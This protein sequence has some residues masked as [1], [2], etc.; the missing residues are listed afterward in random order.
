VGPRV[1]PGPPQSGRPDLDPDRL[2]C[3]ARSPHEAALPRPGASARRCTTG[4]STGSPPRPA[5]VAHPRR[6]VRGGR[7]GGAR[8]RFRGVRSSPGR[9][10]APSGRLAPPV[11]PV[12]GGRR[13]GRAVVLAGGARLGGHDLPPCGVRESV[14]P[15]RCMAAPSQ[16]QSVQDAAGWQPA[17]GTGP[18]QRRCGRPAGSGRGGRGGPGT[19]V[20]V[21]AAAG[22]ASGRGDRAAPGL[23]LP[24]GDSCRGDLGQEDGVHRGGPFEVAMSGPSS[25]LKLT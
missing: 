12:S 10:A 17:A 9:R 3:P 22:P 4:G 15:V 23:A 2:T 19:G 6:R 7:T 25:V 14:V 5:S 13:P 8:Q 24:V 16:E 11:P 21:R 1:R 20:G 18:A